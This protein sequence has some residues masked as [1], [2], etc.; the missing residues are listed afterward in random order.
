M[1]TYVSHVDAWICTWI[2]RGLGCNDITQNIV[3]PSCVYIYFNI[4][5]LAE[6]VLII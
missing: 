4:C 3:C 5:G 6:V 1:P 2:V